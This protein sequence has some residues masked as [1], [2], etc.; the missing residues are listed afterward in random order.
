MEFALQVSTKLE[1]LSLIRSSIE[2]YL[3]NFGDI[4]QGI[5]D[6][7]LLA[8]EEGVSNIIIHGYQGQPGTIDIR[9]RRSSDSLAVYLRDDAS[10][11]NPATVPEPDLTLPLEQ[12]PVGGLGVHMMR[13]LM[14][15]M[16]HRVTSQG[17]NELTLIKK[18]IVYSSPQSPR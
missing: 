18:D 17:G 16:T 4:P 9:L 1:N 6:D 11:F 3:M 12:R 13:Q 8:V 5:I 15:E 14:D 2:K 10:P 7:V